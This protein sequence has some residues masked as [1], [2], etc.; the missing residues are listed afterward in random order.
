MLLKNNVAHISKSTFA[1]YS[2]A[3]N[4][5]YLLDDNNMV[6]DGEELVVSNPKSGTVRPINPNVGDSFLDTKIT[7]PKPLW[8]NGESWVDA[9][10][11][12]V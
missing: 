12:S 7:P 10:G 1:Y 8:W 2:N 4:F 3:N 6:K 5:A 11:A 9:T